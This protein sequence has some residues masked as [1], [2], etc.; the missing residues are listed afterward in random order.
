[1]GE[2]RLPEGNLARLP[3]QSSTTAGQQG[4]GGRPAPAPRAVA[5]SSDGSPRERS[6]RYAPASSAWGAE[7]MS[8]IVEHTRQ[9]SR[10][11]S[12]GSSKKT[13]AW[14][15]T[16]GHRPTRVIGIGVP[17]CTMGVESSPRRRVQVIASRS[18]MWRDLRVYTSHRPPCS[19]VNAST[20]TRR[21]AGRRLAAGPARGIPLAR[22][23][24]RRSHSSPTGHYDPKRVLTIDKACRAGPN[25]ASCAERQTR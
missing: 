24:Q 10:V 15:P 19:E 5:H 20:V 2:G 23:W 3:S 22:P 21:A 6:C 25:L 9:C 16:A 1:M 18:Q 17:S 7:T 4:S 13:S 11:G 8:R 12:A 14:P